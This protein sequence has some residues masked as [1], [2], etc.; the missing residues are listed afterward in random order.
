MSDDAL[1][2]LAGND[3]LEGLDGSDSYAFG[4]GSGHDVIREAVTIVNLGDDDRLVFGAGILPGD[5]TFTRDVNDLIVTLAS[6]DT[7]RI[8]GQFNFASWFAWNDIEHFDFANGTSLTDIQVAAAMLGGTSGSDH[9]VGTF[10]T[11]VLDGGAGND[12]LEGG[13]EADIYVFGL[14]YGEDEI[15]ET[16]TQAILSEQDQLRFGPGI[17]LEDLAFERDGNDLIISMVG[18]SDAL[19]ITGQFA[20]SSWYTWWDVDQFRFDDGSTLSA[21]DVQ[22]IILTGTTDDDHMVGFMTGDTL[23]G[24]A[25]R[26]RKGA[27]ASNLCVRPRYDMMRSWSDWRRDPSETDAVRFER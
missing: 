26:L 8:E 20:Y 21:V 3:I 10:R 23:N 17:T 1:N 5:V 13:D 2:G 7:M 18:T 19:T 14:G 16:V 24:G 6:G 25:A 9:L 27:T 11:D 12:L 4:I 15:R 22:Q